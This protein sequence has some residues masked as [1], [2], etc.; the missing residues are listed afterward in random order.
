MSM[1]TTI[2]TTTAPISLAMLFLCTTDPS[3]TPRLI[4]SMG[5][6]PTTIDMNDQ[7]VIASCGVT[8]QNRQFIFGG[9]KDMRQILQIEKCRLNSIGTTPFKSTFAACS[10]TSGVIILCFGTGNDDDDDAKLCRQASSPNGPW[11]QM[12]LST[13]NHKST[14]IATSPDAFLAV[15]DLFSF[16]A[17]LY[18]FGTSA[19]TTTADFPFGGGTGLIDYDMI[20][21]PD[22]RSY[23]VVGG[24]AGAEYNQIA[25]FKDGEWTDAGRLNS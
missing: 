17:E 21:I 20:Y 7:D 8:F 24:M 23:L 5:E 11:T 1:T 9:N 2:M 6:L 12:A 25:Q 14:S 15:G 10:C 16:K 22:D 4:D 3:N 18:N 13:F 19:W